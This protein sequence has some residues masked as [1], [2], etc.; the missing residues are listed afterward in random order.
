MIILILGLSLWFLLKWSGSRL[1][2][3]G[4][5]L[6]PVLYMATRG[7]GI[8]TGEQAVD[9]VRTLLNERR[10]QSL[11][12]RMTN[13]NLWAAHALEQPWFGWGGW[14]RNFAYDR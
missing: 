1:P 9:L 14:G 5:I 11:E 12:F 2:A 7:S 10:A 13:E 3:V 8:W 4:L 6:V